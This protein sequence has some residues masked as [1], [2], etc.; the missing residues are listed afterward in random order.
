M[1][2]C[3]TLFEILESS[4]ILSTFFMSGRVCAC[5]CACAISHSACI[6]ISA[7]R[8]LSVRGVKNKLALS[9]VF[10]RVPCLCFA[11]DIWTS[12]LDHAFGRVSEQ[13]AN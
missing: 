12:L 6:L 10:W 9:E 3:A 4:I 5:V 13:D 11:C 2:H 8:S 7:S 1:H